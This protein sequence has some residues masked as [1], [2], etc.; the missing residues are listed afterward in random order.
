MNE[1]SFSFN[2]TV[3]HF[4]GDPTPII[5]EM[6]EVV[7]RVNYQNMFDITVIDGGEVS[8]H[9]V[10]SLCRLRTKTSVCCCNLQRKF[11]SLSNKKSLL[12]NLNPVTDLNAYLVDWKDSLH[13]Y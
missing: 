10:A 2:Q 4:Y 11:S 5:H 13:K 3:V 1:E 7:R 6:F 12:K 9:S 8:Y